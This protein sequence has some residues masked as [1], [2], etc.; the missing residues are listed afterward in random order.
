MTSTALSTEQEWLE[1]RRSGIG[2]SETAAVLGLSPWRSPH[3]VWRAKVYGETDDRIGKL[4]RVRFGNAFEDY[5]ANAYAQLTGRTLINHGRHTIFR[6]PDYPWLTATLDREV[7][8]KDGNA[9]LEIK[10]VEREWAGGEPPLPYIVQVQQQCFVRGLKRGEIACYVRGVEDAAPE[11]FAALWAWRKGGDSTERELF[12]QA[13]EAIRRAASGR[14]L[15]P[16]EVERDDAFIERA[17]IPITRRFWG[18]VQ[19]REPLPDGFP[20]ER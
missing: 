12:D 1:E 7:D 6:H 14:L 15:P 5:V 8:Y 16:F 3:D 18:Y 10:V 19:R 13:D 11:M 4:R 17:L 2:A 9:A 20:Q